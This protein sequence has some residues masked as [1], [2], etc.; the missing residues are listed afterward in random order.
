MTWRSLA[1]LGRSPRNA[2]ALLELDHVILAHRSVTGQ[3]HGEHLT[4]LP[5]SLPGGS[6][7][8][9]AVTVPAWLKGRVGDELKDPLGAGLDLPAGTCDPRN[10]M[11]IGHANIQA[12]G[13][14]RAV[15]WTSMR[16]NSR[17]DRAEP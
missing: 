7:G 14:E 16:M 12:P 10:V 4:D 9:V 3:C 15:S 6:L 8:E 11:V 5:D 1:G 13:A 17:F 2:P